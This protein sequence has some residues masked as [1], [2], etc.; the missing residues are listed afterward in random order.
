MFSLK[1]SCEAQTKSA[2]LDV[3]LSTSLQI[4]GWC[5]PIVESMV[6]ES[7]AYLASNSPFLRTGDRLN[8]L[9]L[10][11]LLEGRVKIS[12]SFSEVVMISYILRGSI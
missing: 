11:P 8:S 4:E 7:L 10:S 1:P 5:S 9:S 3:F 2:V 6:L 12:V